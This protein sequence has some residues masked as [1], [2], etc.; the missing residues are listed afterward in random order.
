LLLQLSDPSPNAEGVE[1]LPHY[2]HH[3]VVR[4]SGA[5]Y[6]D[7]RV[8]MTRYAGDGVYPRR[9]E[10]AEGQVSWLTFHP[11]IDRLVH[12]VDPNGVV[13]ETEYD[14]FGRPRRQIPDGGMVVRTR[15]FHD[16]AA[17]APDYAFTVRTQADDGSEIDQEF[18]VLGRLQRRRVS[19]FTDWIESGA[20]YDEIGRQDTTIR[21]HLEDDFAP[22]ERVT[23][24]NLHRVAS[25]EAPDGSSKT[26]T[27]PDFFSERF[28]DEEANVQILERNINGWPAR[29]SELLRSG[30]LARGVIAE[31]GYRPFG[32]L[33]RTTRY[34]GED[35]VVTS[36]DYD[37]RGC[38]IRVVDPDRGETTTAYDGF[39]DVRQ[40]IDPTGVATR[41]ARDRLGRTTH[42][43]SPEGT[44]RFVWDTDFIGALGSAES[45]DDVMT[46]FAYDDFGRLEHKT[47]R[48]AGRAAFARWVTTPWWP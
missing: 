8:T 11:G 30:S 48:V 35:P 16:I 3:F 38:L 17:A 39:G 19:G 7:I 20:T 29:S 31:F 6:G 46:E 21:P 44:T 14:G 27:Y 33:G 2:R 15:Y 26:W 4:T 47:L 34:K 13:T 25:I 41:F 1:T 18:D 24:D 28:T 45:T 23:Y 40:T 37:V 43:Q 22:V 36:F 9:L 32:L 12:T 5:A 10:N 42:E